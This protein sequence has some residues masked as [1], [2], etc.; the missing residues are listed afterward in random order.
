MIC[1]TVEAENLAAI[2]FLRALRFRAA[3]FKRN[4]YLDNRDGV[5]FRY[6]SDLS[7]DAVC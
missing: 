2:E 7:D 1:V 4:L 5:V 3:E 6:E